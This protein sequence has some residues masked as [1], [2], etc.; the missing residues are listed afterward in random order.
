MADPDKDFPWA[1]S[2]LD[3]HG[4]TLPGFSTGAIG[5]GFP[6]RQGFLIRVIA[7]GFPWLI[8]VR[9]SHGRHRPW[10]SMDDREKAL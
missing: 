9:I 10:I 3:F 4:W 7:L 2:P 1:P 5:L 6:S 8:Q